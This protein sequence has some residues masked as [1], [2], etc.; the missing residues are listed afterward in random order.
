MNTG[1]PLLCAGSIRTQFSERIRSS[2]SHAAQKHPGACGIL[3]GTTA[4]KVLTSQIQIQTLTG[5]FNPILQSRRKPNSSFQAEKD[6]D[7]R[8]RSR[9]LTMDSFQPPSSCPS[10]SLLKDISNFKTPRRPSSHC[11][12]NTDRF[13]FESPNPR[14]FT[15]SKQTPCNAYSCRRTPA[16]STAAARRLKAF[17]IEQSR[18]SR[19]AHLQKQRSLKTLSKSLTAWLNFLLENPRS[20]GCDSLP[21]QDEGTSP[22]GTGKRDTGPR[23][24]VGPEATWRSPKRQR[25]LLW[26][27]PE[28]SKNGGGRPAGLSSSEFVKLRDSLKDVCSFDDLAERMRVYLSL[29]CCREIFNMMT[30]VTKVSTIKR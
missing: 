17:E 16:R 4:V 25:A 13:N 15:A 27:I 9:A 12:P 7:Q 28:E 21:G 6:S 14:F 11:K 3:H 24:G 18:S 8:S 23:Q 22:T 10:S 30:L 5:S 1:N 26:K 29:D 20:C 2:S 19:K